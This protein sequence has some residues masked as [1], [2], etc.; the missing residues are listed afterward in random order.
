MK[1]HVGDGAQWF[2]AAGA[3]VGVVAE[4]QRPVSAADIGLGRAWLNSQDGVK[5]RA[6]GRHGHRHGLAVAVPAR[7]VGRDHDREEDRRPARGK[8]APFGRGVAQ[9]AST[10][11]IRL[12]GRG[13]RS[14]LRGRFTCGDHLPFCRWSLFGPDDRGGGERCRPRP[15]MV[16]WRDPGV[17]RARSAARRRGRPMQCPPKVPRQVLD[18]GG[19]GH[20]APM[21]ASNSAASRSWS[22]QIR[23]RNWRSIRRHRWSV[24]WA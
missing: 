17:E 22:W 1:C 2:V 12:G 21:M 16:G 18:G 9:D 4:K 14:P 15:P 23:S 6:V 24:S 3:G 13:A 20:S 8:G 10:L 5:V 19:A 7:E 11:A